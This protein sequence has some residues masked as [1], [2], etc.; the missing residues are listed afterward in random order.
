MGLSNLCR[1]LALG[2]IRLCIGVACASS[3]K[4]LFCVSRNRLRRRVPLPMRF[5]LLTGYR[6]H[7]RKNL[8]AAYAMT[9]AISLFRLILWDRNV[10]LGSLRGCLSRFCISCTTLSAGYTFFPL[11]RFSLSLLFVG[12]RNT[13]R[14]FF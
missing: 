4:A 3:L 8:F 7:K 10:Y 14:V 13:L 5:V 12:Q 2:T 1:T 9:P 6:R 11:S